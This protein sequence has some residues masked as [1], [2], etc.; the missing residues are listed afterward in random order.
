MTRHALD[1]RD[2]VLVDLA[3][4]S[5]SPATLAEL[6][7]A[8]RAVLAGDVDTLDRALLMTDRARRDEHLR[9]AAELIPA[10]RPSARARAEALLSEIERFAAAVWPRARHLDAPPAHW[11][12]LRRELWFAFRAGGDDIP[13]SVRQY[14]RLLRHETDAM[15][16]SSK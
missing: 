14:E 13:Q 1:R 2:R 10:P 9:R 3:S 7:A 5:P 16:H 15:S 6:A 8:A 4:G 11:S 12:Q